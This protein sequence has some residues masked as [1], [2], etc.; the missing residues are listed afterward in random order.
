MAQE[1][2]QQK[3]TDYEAFVNE[4]LRADLK[5]V[6]DARDAVYSDLSEYLQLRNVIEKIQE[7]GVG[8]REL[9][10]MVDIGANFYAHV[11]VPDSSRIFVAVGFGFYVEFT[12]PEAMNFI[13]RKVDHLN[14]K[15]SRLAEEASHINAR[16]K[17][18]LEGLRELQFSAEPHKESPRAVW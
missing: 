11:K 4:R 7:H 18:V 15:G 6:L 17:L 14:E 2:L 12:L 3:I 8:N 5:G 10:T 9:K 1:L 13:Q 16:I